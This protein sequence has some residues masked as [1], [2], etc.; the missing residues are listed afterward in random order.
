[1][2][3]HKIQPAVI[4]A[5]IGV[6]A[7]SL[8]AYSA[9]KLVAYELRSQQNQQRVVVTTTISDPFPISVDPAKKSITSNPSA[10][11]FYAQHT[12]SLSASLGSLSDVFNWIASLIDSNSIYRSLAGADSRLITIQSGD[13]KEEVAQSLGN[14]LNWS[15]AQEGQFMQAVQDQ[16]AGLP[17]GMLS[18]GTYVVDSSMTPENIASLMNVAFNR[19]IL[20]HYSPATA[21]KVPVIQALTVASLLEREAKGP[22]DMRIISGIIWNRLFKNMNL[23]LDA[24]LQY[25]KGESKTGV[26]WQKVVP[27][28]K[29]L[30]SAYNTYEHA[31]LPPGP[32]ANPSVA[33]VIA[34]L[35]PVQT[36]CIY[37]FHDKKGDFHCSATYPEHVALLKKYYGRGK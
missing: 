10:D 15:S 30:A 23:Q 21:Q 9:P 32:I 35:N 22:D 11:A 37:Y 6:V 34:A 31:G 17:E 27:K 20:T 33:A 19:A 1:M 36:D 3:V 2:Q 13:R 26:W 5:T 24:S 8:T 14:A 25:A 28:D 29:Y 18:P 7:V 12:S 16:S 4:V